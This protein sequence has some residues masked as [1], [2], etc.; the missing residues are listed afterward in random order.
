VQVNV[1]AGGLS[2]TTPYGPSNPF[3]LGT[4]QLDANG[5]T[6]NASANFPA[7]GDQLLI[8]D[9]RAGNLPWVAY[10][11]TTD[12]TSGG[13]GIIDGTGLSFTSVTPD[14]IAGNALNATTNPVLTQDVP[15]VKGGPHQFANAAAGAGSV[16]VQGV[17]GLQA[18]SSTQAG[19]YTATVTFT[20]S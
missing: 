19:L 8:T 15:S 20:V 12:F 14:Y 2:I 18:P 17:L 5:S 11:T 3:D 16:K 6:F 1:P 9:T 13:S 10:V 4:M 7:S